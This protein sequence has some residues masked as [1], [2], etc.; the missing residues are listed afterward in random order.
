[1]LE[2]SMTKQLS[3][4]E[5][6]LKQSLLQEVR[7]NNEKMDEKLNK[8]ITRKTWSDDP[9]WNVEHDGDTANSWE[10][11]EKNRPESVVPDLREIMKEAENEKLLEEN[12]K[13]TRACNIILHGVSETADADQTLGKQRDE[14]YVSTFMSALGLEIEYKAMYRLG[15][16][17]AT[18]ENS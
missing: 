18:G 10:T 17:N 8:L 3:Q 6:N 15:K 16:R 14:E 12:E 13:K 5:N 4:I 11:S 2:D 7:A 1:M 9:S